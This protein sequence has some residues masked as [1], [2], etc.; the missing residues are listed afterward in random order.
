MISAAGCV[1]RNF[2]VDEKNYFVKKKKKLSTIRPLGNFDFS[3][4]FIVKNSYWMCSALSYRQTTL[5]Y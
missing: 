2:V 5:P 1:D 3:H 4:N